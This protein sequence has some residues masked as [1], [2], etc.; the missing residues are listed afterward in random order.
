MLAC[1]AAAVVC[2]AA[3]LGAVG[4]S[5][6]ELYGGVA[7]AALSPLLLGSLVLSRYDFWPAAL[8]AGALAA[9]ASA[10]PRLGLLV[11]GAAV[12]AKLYPL[13][14][15]PI[16]LLYVARRHGRREALAALAVFATVVVLVFL[17]FLLASPGGVVD[18][19]RGRRAVRS[20]SRASAPAFC[21]RPT[22]SGSTRRRSFR[23]TARR[24]SPAALPDASP[25]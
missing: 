13:V 11:L 21:S 19:S 18:S 4:S 6:G 7:L 14:L 17:P 9:L 10:R 3:A 15:L 2:V 20:R 24:T 23:A 25:P 22:A 8:T 1:A 12:S 5:A 16:A